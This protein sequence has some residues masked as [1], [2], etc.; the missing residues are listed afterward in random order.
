M[1]SEQILQIAKVVVVR[2]Q[3]VGV[4]ACPAEKCGSAEN[5][6]LKEPHRH[7]FK[8][9]MKARVSD[10]NREIEF[11]DLLGALKRRI[12]LFPLNLGMWSCEMIAATLL[13][14]V[15]EKFPSV[16]FVSVFEDGENGAELEVQS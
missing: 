4:H 10:G 3:F 13:E 5:W 12:E 11:F 8:V 6:F 16:F 2:T 1:A 15:R 9:E 14:S 7:L